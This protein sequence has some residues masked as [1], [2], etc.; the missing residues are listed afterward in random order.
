MF[1][2]NFLYP[3]NALRQPAPAI[4]RAA[5]KSTSL[6]VMP[7]ESM[8]EISLRIWLASRQ[9]ARMYSTS[10]RVLM[11]IILNQSP[12]IGENS[13][14][15]TSGLHLDRPPSISPTDPNRFIPV[16]LHPPPQSCMVVARSLL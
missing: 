13:L 3:R 8:D 14:D 12:N 6:V 16:C 4:R 1:P 2:G 10:C 11:G 9:A 5:A 15:V 7:G